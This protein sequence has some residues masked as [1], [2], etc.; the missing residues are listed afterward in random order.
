MHSKSIETININK[1]K[2]IN[3]INKSEISIWLITINSTSELL[4]VQN[5]STS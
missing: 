2:A 3:I 4:L 1:I 5:T